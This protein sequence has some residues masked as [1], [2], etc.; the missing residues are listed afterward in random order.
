M[1]AKQ[2]YETNYVFH[3]INLPVILITLMATISFLTQ[4]L[5]YNFTLKVHNLRRGDR[6]IIQHQY[7]T[8]IYLSTS[9]GGNEK[10]TMG[11][12]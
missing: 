11:D 6:S 2:L 10:A 3:Q 7:A 4:I 1:L 5:L 9:K 8:D 12:F